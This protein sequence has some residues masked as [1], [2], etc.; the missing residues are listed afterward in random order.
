MKTLKEVVECIEKEIERLEV[1]EEN[2]NLYDE[3]DLME[4]IR[5]ETYRRVQCMLKQIKE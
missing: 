1:N 4:Q 3:C 5:L 2:R